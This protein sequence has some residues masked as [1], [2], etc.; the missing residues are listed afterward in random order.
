MANELIGEAYGW[1]GLYQNRDCSAM[2]RDMFSPFGIWLPRHSEDQAR[3]GGE[4]IDLTTF[5][6]EEKEK[7]IL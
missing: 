3:E 7:V 2:V 5:S 6:P 4:F 1:G